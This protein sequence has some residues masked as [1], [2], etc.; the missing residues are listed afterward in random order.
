[1]AN[2]GRRSFLIA[3]VADVYRIQNTHACNIILSVATVVHLENARLTA[4]ERAIRCFWRAHL[5]L[6][7][8]RAEVTRP[9]PSVVAVNP[10]LQT[11][12]PLTM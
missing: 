1:M 10:P 9:D 8:L 4:L 11:I 5:I 6:S 12:R 2:A 3:V 7:M